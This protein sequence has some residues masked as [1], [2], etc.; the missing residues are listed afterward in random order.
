MIT[1]RMS[2]TNFRLLSVLPTICLACGLLFFSACSVIPRGFSESESQNARTF[3]ALMGRYFDWYTESHPAFSTA[4]GIH[5]YD[6]KMEDYS[7]SGIQKQILRLRAFQ[8]QLE[9]V[10]LSSLPISLQIDHELL[11]NHIRTQLLDLEEVRSWET[12]PDFYPT[13]VSTGV[14]TLISQ[15]YAPEAERFKAVI[16]R[17]KEIPKILEAGIAH[18]KNPPRIFTEVAIEQLP[19]AISF[20]ENDVPKAFPDART[21]KLWSEF[22]ETHLK[23][24]SGLRKY[25]TYLTQQLL[26]KSKGD[27][28]LGRS[29]MEKKLRYEDGV[30]ESIEEL[31]R[32]GWKDLRKNQSEFQATLKKINPA[33]PNKALATYLKNH[34]PGSKVIQTSRQIVLE[35]RDFL[36]IRA[37]VTLPS[38]ALPEVEET[39]SFQRALT[40]AS[41]ESPGA[42]ETRAHQAYYYLTLPEP[43]WSNEKTDEYL[44]GFTF[45]RLV[46]TAIHEAYPGHYTQYLW[47]KSFATQARKFIFAN[48]N[49]EGWAHYCEQMMLDEGYGNGDPLLRLGQLHDA[50]LRNAR[51]LVAL[52]MHAGKMSLDQGI[53]FFI[54]EGYQAKPAAEMET[55]RGAS[56]P[57]YLYYTLG[58]LQIL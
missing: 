41:L 8:A 46:S 16:A 9:A 20:F 3:N 45:P 49:M 39:P 1:L 12:N 44:Q 23:A 6:L 29:L 36:K 10:R 21:S 54:R 19:G 5:T 53:Q 2:C 18:L 51:Y 4:V 24:I 28:R 57:T 15:R 13:A 30:Q 42:F 38:Q 32:M 43:D 55:K 33:E 47:Q 34:P 25:E 14:Y 7:T 22:N 48:T 35:L 11:E 40:E 52:E 17:E 27:F 50:L 37:I 26:P 31:L 58:K 56:D